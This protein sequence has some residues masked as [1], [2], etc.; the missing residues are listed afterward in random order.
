MPDLPTSDAPHGSR[1]LRLA[2]AIGALLVVGASGAAVFCLR[3]RQLQLEPPTGRGAYAP[4]IIRKAPEGPVATPT[5][6]PVENRTTVAAV[7]PEYE[8]TRECLECTARGIAERLVEQLKAD[9]PELSGI[10]LVDRLPEQDKT[11][12]TLLHLLQAAKNASP[13]RRPAWL[14]A[15]DMVA[16]HVNWPNIYPPNSE[17]QRKLDELKGYGLTFRWFE[18][19][20]DYFSDRVPLWQV[21]KD[22]SATP[23][24][25]DAFALLLDS[26]WDTSACC[27][28]GSNAFRNVIREGERFLAERPNSA[29]RLDVEFALAEAYET[30]WSLSRAPAVS[31]NEADP[32][33]DAYRESADVARGKA[34]AYYEEIARAAPNSTQ[35]KCSNRSL[36]ML[37]EN[38]DTHQRRFFCYCD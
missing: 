12:A 15:A 7:Y 35:A 29:R 32:S 6:A 34:I 21:W 9:F 27:G 18:T 36:E 1:R 30:W 25:E 23:S 28:K 5:S 14:L 10:P 20:G 38:Q 4:A 2:L 37:K 19:G 31:D 17:V 22:Y 11:Y 24:G 13:E 16:M 26:G 8:A 33:P 3:Y